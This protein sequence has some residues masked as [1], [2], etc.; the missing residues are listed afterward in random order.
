MPAESTPS[1]RIDD[2]RFAT[3]WRPLIFTVLLIA[4]VLRLL[5]AFLVERHV[6]N[7]GREFFIEGDANGYWD[8]AQDIAA[9][10][11][12]AVHEPPR[13]VLR[14]PGFPLLLAAVIKVVGDSVFAA[15][16]VL[17]VAGTICCWLTYLLGTRLVMRRVGFWAA[18]MMAV[19]P[20][21]IGNSVLILSETWFT[22]WMLL[23]LLVLVRLVDG[24]RGT[25]GESFDLSGRLLGRALLCGALIGSAVLVRPGFLPW[26]AVAAGTVL[27]LS[28]TQFAGRMLLAIVVFA[29][30]FAV[31]FPWAVRNDSVTGHYV[32]TSLWSGPSLYDGLNPDADGSSDMA[33]FDREN[34]MHRMSEFEMNAHYQ[35]KA[36]QFVR[37]NTLRAVQLAVSK[38]ARFLQVVPNTASEG[39]EIWVACVVSAIVFCVLILSGLRS[40]LLDSTG[41]VVVLGPFL[42]FALVHMV[43]VGS[44]RYRLPTEFPLS[45]LAAAGLRQWLA[46]RSTDGSTADSTT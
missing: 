42:L 45:V 32:F 27:T 12:Y 19:H 5:A 22:V 44:L 15:R 11:E 40:R 28:K 1:T 24:P 37:E 16:C 13:R 4:L 41:L 9:G 10:R 35:H 30:C 43:F 25:P 18:L 29:G 7:A 2:E 46:A 36:L 20:W 21:Q 34:V 17:A 23:S 33:F 31:I 14:T 8:L 3:R 39:W 26:L 38:I 6:Q